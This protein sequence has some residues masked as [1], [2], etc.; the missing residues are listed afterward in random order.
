M[1][2]RR[3]GDVE[4]AYNP[5]ATTTQPDALDVAAVVNKFKYL[6][7]APVKAISQLQPNLPELNG[8]IN[9]I[10]VLTV[11]AAVKQLAYAYSG[12]CPCPSTVT[13]GS[14]ACTSPTPCVTAYGAGAMCVKTCNGGDNAGDPCI[15]N[16]HCP[17]GGTCGSPFC[18][19]RC[20]RCSP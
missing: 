7:G 19:D 14:T 12:P 10:D 18:R 8:D 2:T 1:F 5:P 20:G 3:S 13:C 17:G 6:P 16:S 15:N 4:Q 9:A 11:V